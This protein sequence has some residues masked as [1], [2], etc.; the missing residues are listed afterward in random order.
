MLGDDGIL[1]M[2]DDGAPCGTTD[3]TATPRDCQEGSAL[4]VNE[5]ACRSTL[6]AA[7]PQD[8]GGEWGLRSPTPCDKEGG[9]VGS[10]NSC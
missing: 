2:Q 5:P 4:R 8:D 7:A 10:E 9:E 1:K 3:R 6:M